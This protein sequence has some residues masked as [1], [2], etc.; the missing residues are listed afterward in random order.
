MPDRV[1]LAV[2]DLSKTFRVRGAPAQPLTALMRRIEA[3][4]APWKDLQGD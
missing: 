3:S 1:K 4:I 2:D